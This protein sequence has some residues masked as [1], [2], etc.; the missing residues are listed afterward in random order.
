MYVCVCH[1]VPVCFSH[2][3]VILLYNYIYTHVQAIELV[4]EEEDHK[5][6]DV[7]VIFAL[8][9]FPAKSKA[10]RTLVSNKIKSKK[11]T[12]NII[13]NFFGYKIPVRI[14]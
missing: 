9:G 8:H 3:S 12:E 7:Y 13:A 10:V 1:G 4:D 11:F 6:I 2:W 14:I 5:L